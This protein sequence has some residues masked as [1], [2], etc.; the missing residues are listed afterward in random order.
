MEKK[1]SFGITIISRL[2][3]VFGLLGLFIVFPCLLIFLFGS[4]SD[5]R[6]D[7]LAIAL[8]WGIPS[9][10]LLIMSELTFRLKPAGRI[11]HLVIPIILIIL[12]SLQFSGSIYS[13]LLPDFDKLP[14]VVAICL[15]LFLIYFFTRPKV[16][17]QFK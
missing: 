7:A 9:F 17:E 4:E 3:M 5:G 6:V 10:T 15:L 1:R 14:F 16:K 11:M 13:L 12:F 8:T 2:E